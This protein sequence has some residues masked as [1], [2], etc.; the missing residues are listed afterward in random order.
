MSM[1]SSTPLILASPW[2]KFAA[3]GIFSTNIRFVF[4]LDSLSNEWMNIGLISVVFSIDSLDIIT[5]V[6]FF[7]CLV[8]S[9]G[10][11]AFRSFVV[12]VSKKRE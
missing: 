11:R 12:L 8:T 6:D 9:L 5:G 3:S 7:D 1:F 4:D 2:P 10:L